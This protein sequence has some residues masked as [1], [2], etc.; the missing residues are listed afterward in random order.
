MGDYDLSRTHPRADGRHVFR[1]SGDP[2]DLDAVLCVAGLMRKGRIPFVLA[3][4]SETT[5]RMGRPTGTQPAADVQRTLAT[6]ELDDDPLAAG[7]V[8]EYL[9]EFGWQAVS[10]PL[11]MRREDG[12][13]TFM[14][15]VEF[16]PRDDQDWVLF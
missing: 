4:G 6:F 5:N 3:P 15:M 10:D 14:V 8:T 1:T 11:P 16:V 13:V 9:E 2:F 7:T 12:R